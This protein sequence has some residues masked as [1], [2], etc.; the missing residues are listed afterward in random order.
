MRLVAK[1]YLSFG[2][3]L[4]I[5]LLSSI[6][7]I[8]SA[9]E[10]A[11]QME[12]ANLAHS[13]YEN[14]L[15][16]S[17]NTYQLFKQFGDAMLLGSQDR[18]E[19]KTALIGKIRKDISQIRE[20]IGL[21]IELVGEQEIEELGLLATI[22]KQIESLLA[23]YTQLIE[24]SDMSAFHGDW[25]RL[26]HVL[27]QKVDQDFN[28]LLQT[29]LEDEAEEVKE[30]VEETAEQITVLQIAAVIFGIIAVIAAAVSLS[31]LVRDIRK[32]IDQ[33][34]AGA[35]ALAGGHLDHR[36]ETLGKS[37]LDDVGHAF[38]LMADEI[39]ARET[40]L[41][42]TNVRL[43]KAVTDRTAELQ[44]ILGQLQTNETNRKRLLADV[45]HELRTPLTIIQ[46]E[47]DIALR[48]GTKPPEVYAEALKKSRDAAKHTARLVDD[49]LFVARREAG[50][51]R[52]TVTKLDLCQLLPEVIDEHR[53]L[54][55]GRGRAISLTTD[56]GDALIRADGDR[57]R[58]V[59]VILLENALRYSS[60]PVMVQLHGAPAGY[61]VSVKDNGPGMSEEEQARAFDRFFRGSNASEHYKE[62]VG[63]G[64][65][66]AKAI[67][68]AHGG[69]I[70]LNC[71]D[72][73]GTTVCFTLPARPRLEAVS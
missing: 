11:F 27:D 2:I 7:A 8:W 29:A 64:L 58:Q 25:S 32:P 42:Q 15:Q 17:N 30:T 45:S 5:A 14:Y 65:P 46:G 26:S 56:I 48:G 61:A 28:S 66:V 22:E 67:V 63:L 41:S 73:V 69:T 23:E 52:I 31:F 4:S 53:S 68:E 9:R 19:R 34:L 44:R 35:R 72:G 3:L 33:L 1:L 13:V 51:T 18:G 39:A 54:A 60:G 43:E 50:E 38:N 36:I 62:G 59:V 71:A 21:E 37:E 10:A 6:M 70:V 57:I 12:R 20:L 40:S 49:L 24:H 47:A 16:L 55:D